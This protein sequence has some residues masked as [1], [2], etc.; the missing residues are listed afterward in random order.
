MTIILTAEQER[1][2]IKAIN[3]SLAHTPDEAPD[4]ALETLRRRLPERRVAEGE[5]GVEKARA[6]ER[7]ALSHPERPPLPETAFL[8]ENMV[9]DGE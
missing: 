2:L 1:V 3:S 4:Q 5:T 7:W 8:R 9:R 6:L